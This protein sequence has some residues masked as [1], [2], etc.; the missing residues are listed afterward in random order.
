MASV[1][2]SS[3]L[4]GSSAHHGSQ[5]ME[6]AGADG[7]DGLYGIAGADSRT[8]F[9]REESNNTSDSFSQA[10]HHQT[11]YPA[12]DDSCSDRLQSSDQRPSESSEVV[13][14]SHPD[15][16]SRREKELWD[17]L[18]L[19]MAARQFHVQ[20][21]MEEFGVADVPPNSDELE[22]QV[23]KVVQGEITMQEAT[24]LV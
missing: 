6:S 18:E 22:E 11:L 16:V 19:V 9:I 2:N 8:F 4:S 3:N 21:V 24:D 12:V 23:W 7:H 1:S 20:K 15:D 17:K 10:S 13:R 14:F 5:E